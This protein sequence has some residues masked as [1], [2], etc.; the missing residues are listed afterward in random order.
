MAEKIYQHQNQNAGQDRKCWGSFSYYFKSGLT[1]LVELYLIFAQADV[2]DIC[3]LSGQL[4]P[5]T[6]KAAYGQSETEACEP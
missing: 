6:V 5:I 1:N 2:L 4:L 3:G